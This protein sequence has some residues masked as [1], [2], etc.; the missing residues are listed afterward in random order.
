[1]K[2]NLLRY[3][4][5]GGALL[6]SLAI[7]N[8]WATG[9]VMEIHSSY[10]STTNV[11]SSAKSYWTG[12]WK[13]ASGERAKQVAVSNDVVYGAIPGTKVLNY[14]NATANALGSTS[15][16]GDEVGNGVSADD[17]G[18]LIYSAMPGGQR[19][20]CIYIVPKSAASGTV[21]DINKRKYM[22]LSGYDTWLRST[23]SATEYFHASGDLYNGNGA[24]WFTD[25]FTVVKV[26][27][28][29]GVSVDGSE[30][31]YDIPDNASHSDSD[32]SEWWAQ[33]RFRPYAEGKYLLQNYK[34]LFDCS[35]NSKGEM[36]CT[37]IGTNAMAANIGYLKDHEILVYSKCDRTSGSGDGEITLYDRT[38]GTEMLT[39]YAKG[40]YEAPSY[41]NINAWC[42]FEKV[43]ETT[44]ALYTFMPHAGFTKFLITASE[45]DGTAFTAT[46]AKRN[47]SN[48]Q[49]ATLTWDKPAYST[50]ETLQ[51]RKRYIKDGKTY[52][53]EWSN[54]VEKTTERTYTHS[55]VYWYNDGDAF[56]KTTVEY[57]V[58]AHYGD[59]EY[60][61]RLLTL[62]AEVEPQL[63]S[64]TIDWDVNRIQNYPGYQKVQ[65]FWK[66]IGTGSTPKYYNIYRDGEKI[67]PRPVQVFNYID[68]KIPVGDHTYYVEAYLSDSI[69][70]PMTT[71]V[72]SVNIIDRDPMKTTYS[73]EVIYN[74]PI[75]TG[76]NMVKPQG[77]YANLLNTN[78]IWYKQAKYHR[79]YWYI[80]QCRDANTTTD[81]G[82]IRLTA[83]NQGI[84][85]ETATRVVTHTRN[86]SLGVTMDDAGNIF[87]R[88]QGTASDRASY[89]YE[90]GWGTIYLK[91][92][93]TA[94]GYR[95]TGIDVDL[96]GCKINDGNGYEGDYLYI[97]RVD[98]Y[99]MEG[100]LSE[101]NSGAEGDT[102]GIAYLY[103][104]GHRTKRSNKIMLKRTGENTIVASLVNKTDITILSNQGTEFDK[105]DENYAF[106]IRYLTSTTNQSTGVVSYSMTSRTDYI[107]NL[108]SRGYFDITPGATPASA[109]QRAIYE[110][111]SRI[112]NA[113]G[114]TIGFNNELF[115][116]TPQSVYSKNTG[117]FI[118]VMG[119]RFTTDANGDDVDNGVANADLVNNIPVA[120]YTQTAIDDGKYTDANCI[121]MYAVHGTIAGEKEVYENITSE[122][123][124]CIYIYQYVPGIRFAK[125]RLV[126]NN[127]FPATPVT[128]EIETAYKEDGTDNVDILG[129]NG[130]VKW[131]KPNYAEAGGGNIN[132]ERYSYTLVIKN[133]VGDTLDLR[134][135][136]VDAVIE[137]ANGYYSVE[138]P[139]NGE[140]VK[141]YNGNEVLLMPND[142][143]TP[144]PYFAYITV[145][146]RN[147]DTE[148]YPNDK[149]QSEQTVDEDKA[150]YVGTGATG[151]VTV[152][153]SNPINAGTDG[154]GNKYVTSLT[155]VDINIDEP[156]FNQ[157]G[158]EEEP[159]SHYEIWVDKDGDGVYEYQ[160]PGFNLMQGEDGV[161]TEVHDGKIPGDYDF[162]NN[163]A[164]ALTGGKAEAE[165]QAN[166]GAT[167]V[168]SP[169]TI[170]FN[171]AGTPYIEGT[172]APT[173]DENP[174]DWKYQVV[175]VYAST[176]EGVENRDISQS[177]TNGM[178]TVT[179]S[180]VTG[181]EDVMTGDIL[182]VYPIP[183]KS[184]LTIESPEAL[185]VVKI[186][187][188]AGVVVK[189][190][191]FNGEST[192]T[193][194]V[195][196]LAAG[197]YFVTVNNQVPVKIIK[198]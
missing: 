130:T 144:R 158:L 194:D 176:T 121:W 5:L 140:N 161:Y 168:P 105:G 30:V 52:Y 63:I 12:D 170:F 162:D 10:N 177:Y 120:Q 23:N 143:D 2:R 77:D 17:A 74:Y 98:Y 150:G 139:F 106:P 60:K 45:S 110:T 44:L 160:L 155:R 25:G 108:R 38:S 90:L 9:Y 131:Q 46:I 89:S 180:V 127:Y 18:N 132:Y 179:A 111:T 133:A 178:S 118:V 169:T 138:Y 35:I 51:Y 119:N 14:W 152:V 103:V 101:I 28:V 187:N 71:T 64:K 175:T 54:L 125:Y 113:G 196:A 6:L 8:A 165:S 79:G 65:L 189:E 29:N 116:I 192:A 95:T 7:N 32:P 21:V 27:I 37:Q 34:G 99:E 66:V 96:T 142:N 136:P 20:Y 87:L 92:A 156:D 183:V 53:T 166:A 123:H 83:D 148:T 47:D 70:T 68:E 154:Q 181:I 1:M 62:E 149:H 167:V 24:L 135:I 184:T 191:L 13:N 81:A 84:L 164:Y 16:A 124:D 97:G 56:Y 41:A 129:F 151:S 61:P 157:A 50:S 197:Y 137:D 26:P 48:Y 193:I 88:K 69:K 33:S 72:E 188:I 82:V 36:T 195:D 4:M 73:I 182:K 22:D 172:P 117:N 15:T 57:R 19:V 174:A 91:D 58:I 80:N 190:E 11:W 86:R 109:E 145:N 159:V 173:D 107:H 112:N 93:S 59:H 75:G 146:Y 186:H 198:Q 76:T 78:G 100:D 85:T 171:V 115:M 147:K 3:L 114:C 67:N 163:E 40:N 134:E 39:F 153:P 141:T 31:V 55:N 128:F 102:K 49:D 104:S 42:E 122:N 126:P 43:N 185:K 94:T